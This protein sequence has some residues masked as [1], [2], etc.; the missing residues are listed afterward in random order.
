MKTL[1]HLQIVSS[2]LICS[3]IPFSHALAATP[4]ME[5][6]TVNYRD[7]LD[8]ALYLHTTEM[9]SVFRLEIREDISIQA[10]NSLLEMANAAQ[11][12]QPSLAQN[13]SAEINL[14]SLWVSQSQG[15]SE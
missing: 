12:S 11:F 6:I 9:L 8:Y 14:A 4:V 3:V 15:I 2:L 10:R 7:P 5:T 13:S 1:I